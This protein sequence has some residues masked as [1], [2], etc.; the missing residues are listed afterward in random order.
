MILSSLNTCNI[1]RASTFQCGSRLSFPGKFSPE[2][3]LLSHIAQTALCLWPQLEVHLSASSHTK[4]CQH[5]NI[6]EAVLTLGPLCLNAFLP[7]IELLGHNAFPCTALVLPPMS[8]FVAE[9]VT[10]QFHHLILME[11]CWMEIPWLPPVLDMPKDVLLW[12]IMLYNLIRVVSV[13]QA[14]KRSVATAFNPFA[15]QD[16]C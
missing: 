6:L 13:N 8:K 14:L 4:Q 7:L 2:W 10:G 12:G 1:T 16:G 15:S 5:Y 3:Y 11:S 9:H